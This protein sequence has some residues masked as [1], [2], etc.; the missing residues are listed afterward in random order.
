ML[1]MMF[2]LTSKVSWDEMRLAHGLKW[3][4]RHAARRV[5]SALRK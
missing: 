1:F 5:D 4:K 2:E 3:R